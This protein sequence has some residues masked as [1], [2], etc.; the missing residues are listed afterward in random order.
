MKS[1]REMTDIVA[2][3]DQIHP[4][5]RPGQGDNLYHRFFDLAYD[6]WPVLSEALTTLMAA[7]ECT[8]DEA[9]RVEVEHRADERQKVL[10]AAE[11]A[12]RR[13]L[14]RKKGQIEQYIR[15]ELEKG[16]GL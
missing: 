5:V 10:D 4:L 16:R 13:H 1:E 15:T 12:I 14:P 9:N 7:I 11:R 2:K 3:L 8:E 6:N